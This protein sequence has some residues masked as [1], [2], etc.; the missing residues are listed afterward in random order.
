[1]MLELDG[2]YICN[3]ELFE[4]CKKTS[5]QKECVLTTFKE[6]AMTDEFGNPIPAIINNGKSTE[7]VNDE[8]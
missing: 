2:M 7:E 8:T 1:M 4:N 6:Y 5:C 3:P